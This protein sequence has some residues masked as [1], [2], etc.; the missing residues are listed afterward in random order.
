AVRQG[1]RDDVDR[2][3]FGSCEVSFSGGTTNHQSAHFKEARIEPSDERNP[4]NLFGAKPFENILID[5][6][7]GLDRSYM[8]VIINNRKITVLEI[9]LESIVQDLVIPIILSLVGESR[10]PRRASGQFGTRHNGNRERFTSRAGN[11]RTTRAH[12]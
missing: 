3:S 7:E 11:A 10:R 4:I 1:F 2:Q 8:A 9:I 12:L 5:E 6:K